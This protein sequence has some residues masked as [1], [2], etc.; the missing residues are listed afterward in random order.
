MS[1]HYWV[2]AYDEKTKRWDVDNLIEVEKFQHLTIYTDEHGWVH[3]EGTWHGLIKKDVEYGENLIKGLE[4]LNADQKKQ[5]V[6]EYA[7]R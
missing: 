2:V 7:S 1:K 6:A 4:Y 5:E 3:D